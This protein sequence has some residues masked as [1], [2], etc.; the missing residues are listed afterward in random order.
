M[1]TKIDV[2]I[3]NDQKRTRNKTEE[4]TMDTVRK[5]IE[6]NLNEKTPHKKQKIYLILNFDK[7]LYDFPQLIVDIEESLPKI[8]RKILIY[9]LIEFLD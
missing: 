4:E 8:K 9:S 1:R 5:N 7:N 2:D 6:D 3:A